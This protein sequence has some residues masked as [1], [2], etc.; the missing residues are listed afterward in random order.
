MLRRILLLVLDKYEYVGESPV[1]FLN[2]V[3]TPLEEKYQCPSIHNFG[4]CMLA[5]AII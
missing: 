4:T 2:V 1:L 3:Y 5:N